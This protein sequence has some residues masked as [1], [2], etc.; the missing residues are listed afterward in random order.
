MGS[1]YVSEQKK[2]EKLI[3]KA[4]LSL[5]IIIPSQELRKIIIM[6]NLF[7]RIITIK[8]VQSKYASDIFMRVVILPHYTHT[9][10]LTGLMNPKILFV[11]II[12]N[13]PI[14]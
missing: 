10:E 2:L 1:T 9:K 8:I 7:N 13:K 14:V 11:E 4:I 3:N 12:N 6:V 5:P